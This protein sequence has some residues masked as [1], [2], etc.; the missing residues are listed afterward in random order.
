MGGSKGGLRCGP[1]GDAKIVDNEVLEGEGF[2]WALGF[3]SRKVVAPHAAHRLKLVIV[4]DLGCFITHGW[5]SSALCSTSL[6]VSVAT[7]PGEEC[8]CDPETSRCGAERI[9]E[10]HGRAMSHQMSHL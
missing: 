2:L 4:G 1:V 10:S 3:C 6:V 8:L 9:P 7:T 5:D